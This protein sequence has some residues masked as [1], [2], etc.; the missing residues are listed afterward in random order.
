[1]IFSIPRNKIPLAII[2]IIPSFPAIRHEEISTECQ[3]RATEGVSR[4]Q[5]TGVPMPQR[6]SL[7]QVRGRSPRLPHMDS[8]HQCGC[9]G[10]AQ[11]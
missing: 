3:S 8:H 10:Y 2:K 4:P 11:V 6:R 5:T 9:Y 1:M 7:C